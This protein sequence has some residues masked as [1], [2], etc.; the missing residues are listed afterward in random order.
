MSHLITRIISA[1]APIYDPVIDRFLGGEAKVRRRMAGRV[2]AFNRGLDIGCGTG[3][4]LSML[5]KT[6]DGELYGLDLS[7]RM[8]RVAV[9]KHRGI[10]F[11][12]GSALRLPFRDSSFDAVFSTMMMHHLTHDERI[13]ALSEI[14]RV[15]KRGGAYYSLEFGNEGLNTVGKAV[16]GLGFLDEKEADGFLPVEKETWEKGLVWR[17]LYLK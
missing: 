10:C 3:M 8:L 12:R 9:K 13:R 15:L 1:I 2:G 17:K 16:T 4:F 11:V 5:D 6:S 7:M 14:R